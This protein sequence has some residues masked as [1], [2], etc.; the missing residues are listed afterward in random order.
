MIMHMNKRIYWSESDLQFIK[1]NYS[2]ITNHQ[3]AKLL[4]R[5]SAESIQNM[6]HRLRL[7]K[8][9]STRKSGKNDISWT[10]DH[11]DYLMKFYGKISADNIAHYLNRTVSSIYHKAHELGLKG[12]IIKQRPAYLKRGHYYQWVIIRKKV[13]DRDGYACKICGYKKHISTHH[14][15]PL[16]EGGSNNLDNLITLCP[17]C[18]AEA[19]ASELSRKFLKEKVV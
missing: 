15:M 16:S 12:K 17:N 3:I 14:I 4:N 1:D 11:I 9:N 10:Q 18:H 7:T 19:D 8:P 13:S 2:K 5:P 6:A